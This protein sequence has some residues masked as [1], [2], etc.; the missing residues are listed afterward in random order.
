MIKQNQTYLNRLHV[1]ID[2]LCIYLSGYVAYCVRFTFSIF[3][4]NLNRDLFV[5]K[6]LL[7]SIYKLSEAIDR[8]D[9]HSLTIICVFRSLYTKALS[10]WQLRAG[11]PVE[12]QSAGSWNFCI[13]HYHF[14]DPELPSFPVSDVL[15]V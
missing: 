6:P 14:P 5:Y 10:A 11:E 3:G 15:C 2:A 9:D 8:C 4:F 12:G 13:Y 1:L 7:F